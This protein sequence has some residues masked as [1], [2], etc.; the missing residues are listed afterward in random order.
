MIKL[1]PRYCKR[2]RR[3]RDVDWRNPG[4]LDYCP[5]CIKAVER[6]EPTQAQQEGRV[7]EK[8][9]K[10]QRVEEVLAWVD[11]FKSSRGCLRCEETDPCALD[12]H[13]IDPAA[14]EIS[15]ST[16]VRRR[17]NLSVVAKELAKCV[18]LCAS[19]HRKEHKPRKPRESAE[20][21]RESSPTLQDSMLTDLLAASPGSTQALE[22]SRTSLVESL[23]SV[24]DALSA[25]RVV[26]T[27]TSSKQC[28]VLEGRRR[29]ISIALMKL[30]AELAS[31]VPP[32]VQIADEKAPAQ[33]ADD[34]EDPLGPADLF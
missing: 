13:H 29:S 8:A 9:R 4:T 30:D 26:S 17:P 23:K 22:L 2:C 34:E 28:S 14:K 1:F 33:P 32:L 18:V 5:K 31:R 21:P 6:K 25:L 10:K 24:T 12:C 11:L 19:C 16:L 15:V 7:R 27:R 20:L 3:R